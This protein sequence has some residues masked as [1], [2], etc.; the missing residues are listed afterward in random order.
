MGQVGDLSHKQGGGWDRIPVFITHRHS[1]HQSSLLFPP[2]Q[3]M[4]ST[5]LT[6]Y[7]VE[8]IQE[9]CQYRFTQPEILSLYR[10]F[11]RLDLKQKG[12]LTADEILGIPEISI[13]PL[14]PRLVQIYSGVN[15]K[16]FVSLL[17]IFSPRASVEEKTAFLFQVYDVDHDGIITK[18]DLRVML[19]ML[20]GS[21]IS[22][23]EIDSI[24]DQVLKSSPGGGAGG[25]GLNLDQFRQVIRASS[26]KSNGPGA[27]HHHGMTGL[28]WM[29]A[30]LPNPH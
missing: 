10:R 4:S 21:A 9:Y 2:P 13:N 11:R 14:S 23:D 5:G 29:T 27:K 16:E 6:Q 1:V 17:S 24:S 28:H 15:F 19:G 25:R 3:G 30:S 20:G 7:D 26:A 12:Y 22:A 18:A 8:S